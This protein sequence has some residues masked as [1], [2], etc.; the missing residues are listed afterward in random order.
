MVE[1][2]R[3][4]VVTVGDCDDGGGDDKSAIGEGDG[5]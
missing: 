1:M 2:V 3:L 5:W 4:V